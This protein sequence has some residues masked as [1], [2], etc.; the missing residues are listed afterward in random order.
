[1]AHRVLAVENVC[2]GAVSR[3]RAA[4]PHSTPITSS[5]VP[6]PIAIGGNGGSRSSSKPGTVGMNDESAI[7]AA[8]RGRPSN[9][10]SAYAII[11]ALREPADHRALGRE[12]E[13]VEPLDER[14]GNT[15][16]NVFGSG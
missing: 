16:E 15:A 1:M 13:A 11:A 14:A 3:S 2:A 12:P 10:L 8:G 6:C 9:R 5:Y 7:T 4:R